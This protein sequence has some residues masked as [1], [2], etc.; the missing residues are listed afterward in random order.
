[1]RKHLLT[2]IFF[3]SRWG[4]SN[5]APA[6][7]GWISFFNCCAGGTAIVWIPPSCAVRAGTEDTD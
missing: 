5:R 4:Y 1:M 7:Q 3:S 2:Q 6:V